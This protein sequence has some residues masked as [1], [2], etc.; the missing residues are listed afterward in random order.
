MR[1]H[2]EPGVCRGTVAVPPSKSMAH[3]TLIC[4]AL[5][6]GETLPIGVAEGEMLAFGL[7][8]APGDALGC[9]LPLGAGV[10]V[11][12]AST[13]AEGDGEIVVITSSPCVVVSPRPPKMTVASSTTST[14]NQIADPALS[15]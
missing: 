12:P 13:V 10:A 3:R 1:V 4:A 15:P 6:E 9:A 8:L 2:F 5:A 11:A 7:A 14:T